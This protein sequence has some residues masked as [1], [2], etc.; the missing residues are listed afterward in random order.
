MFLNFPCFLLGHSTKYPPHLPSS[1]YTQE[2]IEFVKKHY[3]SISMI[4]MDCEM[5]IING[6]KAT[7]N[8]RS[9]LKE[10]KWKVDQ[11]S[12]IKKETK[13]IYSCLQ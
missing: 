5:P 4:L 6:Y 3:K 1:F 10:I 13:K 2:A 12:Q 7:E 11:I 9:F 8:I